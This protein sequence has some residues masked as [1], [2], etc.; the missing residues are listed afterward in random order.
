VK[1]KK[2]GLIFKPKSDYSWSKS[3]CT[4]PTLDILSENNYRLYYG[5]RNEDNFSQIA[6]VDFSINQKEQIV[7]TDYSKRPVLE[8]GPLGNFDDSAVFPSWIL[9]NKNEKW[10]Y[11]IGWMQGKRIPF[12]AA[13]GLA[14]SKDN[15]FTWKKYSPAP[16]LER[17]QIDPSMM[18]SSC[19]LHDQGIYKMWYLTNLSW[20]NK[21]GII[22]PKYHIKYA[23]SLD[24]INWNRQG[25]VCIDFKNPSEF[26]ISRPFVIKEDGIFKMFY[27][28][29]GDEPYRIGYAESSD[30]KSW[31]RMDEKV[32][33]T[34]SQSGFDSHTIEYPCILKTEDKTFMFYNG[35]ENGKDGI[36]VAILKD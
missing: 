33:I 24:G 17:N 9:N 21:L 14:I 10:L 19:V 36:G 15:G 29:Q 7:E 30:G 26:A 32:G 8:L 11:Y 27:S 31:N 20:S 1:W 13:I 35:N 3:H 18:A 2:L 4:V 5:T 23:E 6:S 28:Y 16:L 12:H 34:V 22:R 25:L